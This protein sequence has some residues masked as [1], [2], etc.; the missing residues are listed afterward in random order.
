MSKE[1]PAVISIG[2][3]RHLFLSENPELERMKSCAEETNVLHLIV[4]SLREHK[5]QTKHINEKLYLHPTNSRSRWTMVFDAYRKAAQIIRT[6]KQRRIIIT[7]QDPFEAGVVGY[8]LKKRF[9]IPLTVQEHA[10]AF[11]LVY[12]RKESL[13]NRVRYV[14]GK[15]L[16]QQADVVRVVSKRIEKTIRGIRPTGKITR[17]PVAIDTTKFSFEQ[18]DAV[19]KTETEEFRFLSVARFVPQKNFPIMIRAFAV[20]YRS[21]PNLQLQI[22]GDGPERTKIE[23]EIK[24]EFPET[25]KACPVSIIGWSHDVAGLMREADAYLLTSNY[26]GWARVLIEAL[27]VGLPIVTTDVGC[28]GE[29]V[30]QQ[31]HGL[32]V[33]VGDTEAM[34][35]AIVRM[36]TDKNFYTQIKHNV[37]EIKRENLAG[38]NLSQYG[39]DWVA[40]LE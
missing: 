9:G 12:W 4:F 35:G 10:D 23:A 22:V 6:S 11:S 39:Q 31:V 21:N 2:Y 32:V 20:A 38:A 17:L 5:L 1:K 13:G 15:Y 37:Q 28:A 8:L 25:Q 29:V 34:T 30:E 7:S 36:S 33:P 16:V 3:G 19:K 14:I 27:L 18:F 24:K 40:T 26:E